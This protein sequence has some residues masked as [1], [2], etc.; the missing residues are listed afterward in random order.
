MVSIIGNSREVRAMD[1]ALPLLSHSLGNSER[2]V[3]AVGR[4]PLWF[5]F[6]IV[7]IAGLFTGCVP[8]ATIA[9]M[10]GFNAQWRGFASLPSDPSLSYETEIK[11][12]VIVVGDSSQTRYPGAVATYS[13]PDGIIRIMGKMVNGK[14]VLCPAVIGH[15]IQHALQYQDGQFVNPDRMEEYG[16]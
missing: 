6:L 9:R 15:E 4:R 7:L 2:A 13:H 10:D 5:C 14:I 11:V 16:Y 8:T 3:R 12:K 1:I